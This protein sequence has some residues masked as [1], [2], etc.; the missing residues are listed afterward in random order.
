VHLAVRDITI[1]PPRFT[2]GRIADVGVGH[3]GAIFVLDTANRVVSVFGNDGQYIG[4]LRGSDGG[5]PDFGKLLAQVL[6]GENDDIYVPDPLA[7]RVLVFRGTT[8][9][10]SQEMVLPEHVTFLNWALGSPGELFVCAVDHPALDWLRDPTLP[11]GHACSI[12]VSPED[13]SGF[14]AVRPAAII[15]RLK[16]GRLKQVLNLS[17]D[18]S[19]SKVPIT[20]EVFSSAFRTWATTGDGTLWVADAQRRELLQY[21]DQG[22]VLTRHAIPLEPEAILPEDREPIAQQYAQSIFPQLVGKNLPPAIQFLI[23]FT[24]GGL[25]PPFRGFLLDTQGR[26]WLGTPSTV[27]D[28]LHAR[29]GAS[30]FDLVNRPTCRWTVLEHGEILGFVKFPN[31]FRLTRV[32]GNCAYGF[33]AVGNEGAVVERYN[34]GL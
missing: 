7:L 23:R 28:L 20:V 24:V 1:G 6:A 13:L 3:D 26:A 31:G 34:V 29:A 30:G 15:Y 2:F 19:A 5:Q 17:P 33:R 11:R 25:A 16:R 18:R 21:S 8:Q 27:D 9:Q 10:L 22:A 4:P 32:R 14:L 12:P